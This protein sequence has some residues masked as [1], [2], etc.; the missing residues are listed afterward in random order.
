MPLLVDDDEQV[1][2]YNP[3][4]KRRKP[5]AANEGRVVR[6]PAEDWDKFIAWVGEPAKDIP[7]LRRLANIRPA[8]LD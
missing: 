2:E 5:E 4:M 8:W 6:I 1:S 7:E 3:A